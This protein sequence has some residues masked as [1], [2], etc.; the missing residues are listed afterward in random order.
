[1]SGLAAPPVS[2]S[3]GPLARVVDDSG[4]PV[5][6]A[7]PARRIVALAPALVELAFAAGGGSWVVGA[8]DYS[9]VPPAARALPRV[10]SAVALDIERL[11]A[12]RPDL[13]LAWSGGSSPKLLERLEELGI[14]V[15]HSRI[16]R[17]EAIAT[18]LERF[19][20]LFGTT[21][22]PAADAFRLRLAQLSASAA[23]VGAE[24]DGPPVR[25]F[26]Q[27]WAQ[28]LM[29]INRHHV[30]DDVIRRCGGVNLFADAPTPVPHVGVEAVVVAAPELIIAASALP[31]G[32]ADGS[33]ERWRRFPSLPAVR[34]GGL[35]H[36]EADTIAR[37]APRM[38]DAAEA[39]C[40]AT[41]R[42]RQAR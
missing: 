2:A 33:L 37:P 7:A 6:L 16:E 24:L 12:L 42:A 23:A 39:I 41:A 4:R 17:L 32:A 30:I 9:D 36:L 3:D 29:T 18:T 31:G 20:R 22:S 1:M 34:H 21:A 13:I 28:P 26:Y 35:L 5:R 14:P 40:K 8:V 27:L 11:L 15:F 19:A 25:V 38:L 10:G